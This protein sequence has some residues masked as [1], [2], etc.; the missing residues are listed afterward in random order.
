MEASKVKPLGSISRDDVRHTLHT[1]FHSSKPTPRPSTGG[2]ASA[3][4]ASR[5][6]VFSFVQVQKPKSSAAETKRLFGHGPNASKYFVLCVTIQDSSAAAQ[7]ELHYVQLLSNLSVDVRSAW[8][9]SGLDTIEHNGIGP[10]KTRGAFALFFSGEVTSW[11]WLVDARESATAMHEFLWSVCALVVQNNIS[12]PRLVRLNVEELHETATQLSLQKAYDLDVDLVRSVADM[13]ENGALEE[14]PA[15][16]D[17]TGGKFVDNNAGVDVSGLR[18]S[19]P[20][21]NEALSLLND[22]DWSEVQLLAVEGDLRKKLH[23]LEDENIAFLLSLDGEASVSPSPVVG[24]NGKASAK[25]TS[26]D[27]ILE[28]IDAVQQRV[29]MIQDWTNESDESLGQTSSSMQHFEALNNQLEMHFKNSVSLEEVLARLMARVEIHQ[30]H[31][32]VFTSPVEVFPGEVGGSSTGVIHDR[33]GDVGRDISVTE[34][35]RTTVA[36]VAAMD[37]AITST[38]E[39]PAKEMVAFRTRGDELS[40]LATAFGEKLCTSFD[41]FLQR[42]VKQWANARGGN[43]SSMPPGESRFNRVK[44]AFDGSDEEMNWG[45]TNESLH[46]VL[47]DYQSLFAHANSLDPR[48]LVALRQTYSKQLA[49]VYN[50]HAQS[51]FRCLKDKLPRTSK[52]HFHKPTSLQSR[53]IH[54]SSS[55]FSVGDTMCA[56]PL[57][58]QAL[59]HLTPLVLS[60]QRLVARLFFP[61]TTDRAN[62]SGGKHEL[63]DLTLTMESI[64]EKLLKRMNEF[65]EAA[66]LRNILDALSLV[67]LVN[68]NLEEYRQ[69][70][71]FLYNVM[72]SFQLQMKRMLIKFTEEQETWIS[73]QSADTKMAGVLAPAKKIVNMIARMEES[74]CGKTD[75]STLMSIY[76]MMLPATMQWVDKVAESRPKYASLTRLENYLFLSDNLKAING[77]KELPLAQYA[78]EAHDRYT[79]NLQRYVASVWEYAFK[80]LVPLMASIESLMTTVPA[81]EIQYHSPRQEVRRVLDSTASTFEK[82]VRIM[83]DRMK[84]H[85]RE[86]PK[87]LPSVWK[88][89]IAYGSSRVAVYALVAGDCYQLRFEPSPERG[90]EVLE[91]FAFTSS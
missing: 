58:Q 79:E 91:K 11:Q 62:S 12:L 35:M 59:D 78:T 63:E 45:F 86:N 81:S 39:F 30:Q 33:G 7:L 66:G 4:T 9:L 60:E 13:K 52:H 41:V 21:S 48:I 28:A 89:L 2:G 29:S 88:Q 43:P 6:R 84:K 69:Q 3:S 56:S 77:S 38:Q 68:G 18:L 40:K 53:G 49:G 16:G 85:F 25:G 31:M 37:Q 27:K 76:N 1:H 22:V 55:H 26:V 61:S 71:A 36:A 90:L 23:T 73:A 80:Q 51:L 32:Q 67:V 50:A 34:R 20:E 70:S 42:K 14:D 64:F 8:N 75:D 24:S 72:V 44:T 10:E 82:S 87:M 19:S 17:E 46:T 54:L 15:V 5:K 57:M 83:H 47:G 74:V 65:G